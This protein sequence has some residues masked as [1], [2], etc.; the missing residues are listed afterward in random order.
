MCRGRS[1]LVLVIK[2]AGIDSRVGREDA[3]KLC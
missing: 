2:Q 3:E 1:Q